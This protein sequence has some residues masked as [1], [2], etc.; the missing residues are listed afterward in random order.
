MDVLK[1]KKVMLVL[2]AIAALVAVAL[3]LIIAQPL[4]YFG[5]QT[6]PLSNVGS[7]KVPGDWSVVQDEQQGVW[8]F[9]D[10]NS[11][12]NTYFYGIY[13]EN[14]VLQFEEELI[15]SRQYQTTEYSHLF[16]TSCAY[17]ELAFHDN[18]KYLEFKT[19]DFFPTDQTFHMYSLGDGVSRETALKIA[20]SFQV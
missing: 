15:G 18:N 7:I 3:V 2:A 13:G 11:E 12:N 17:S 20:E 6:I 1:K 16:S 8:Y 9:S 19:I 4:K 5:W 14:D 10:S